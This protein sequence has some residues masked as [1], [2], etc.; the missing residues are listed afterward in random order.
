M[1][2]PKTATASLTAVAHHRSERVPIVVKLSS[3]RL[4]AQLLIII[5]F[6]FLQFFASPASSNRHHLR[7]GGTLQ[8]SPSS[9]SSSS[10]P[11]ATNYHRTTASLIGSH[12]RQSKSSSSSK[13]ASP[14]V[15]DWHSQHSSKFPP[16]SPPKLTGNIIFF[17]SWLVFSNEASALNSA[18]IFKVVYTA[19]ATSKGMLRQLT[20]SPLVRH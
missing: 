11:P 8:S 14:T 5:F 17:S 12:H 16:F 20:I 6:L 3:V 15:T 9:S 2:L 1:C 18:S 19:T 13:A 7:G 4:T 10:P